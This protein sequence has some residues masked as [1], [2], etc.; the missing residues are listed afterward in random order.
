M[1][2]TLVLQQQGNALTGTMQTRFGNTELRGG[3][4]GPD[5]FRFTSTANIQGRTVEITVAGTATGNDMTGTV[6][7]ELGATSFTG[8]RVP[9]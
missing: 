7:S 8:T 4:V 1:P 3:S 6:T 2:G 9:Q 5:G